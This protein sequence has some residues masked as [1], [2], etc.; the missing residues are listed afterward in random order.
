METPWTLTI[1]G[2]Q[3]AALDVPL[4][5]QHKWHRIIARL[6]EWSRQNYNPAV[7]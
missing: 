2:N 1:D 4:D 7:L 5:F 6:N 3:A